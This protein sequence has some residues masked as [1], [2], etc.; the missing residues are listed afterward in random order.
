MFIPKHVHLNVAEV[1]NVYMY[2]TFYKT[3]EHYYLNVK[4]QQTVH[5]T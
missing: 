5:F 4:T 2:L 3:I 1:S